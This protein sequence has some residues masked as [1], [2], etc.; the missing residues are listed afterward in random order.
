MA[1]HAASVIG[2]ST[3]PATRVAGVASY[4]IGSLV[5]SLAISLLAVYLVSVPLTLT[6]AAVV[7]SLAVL[8]FAGGYL[9]SS[10]APA[11]SR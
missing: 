9:A 6:T 10:A 4:L 1:A 11:R 2:I 3:V 5:A 8:L 7:S